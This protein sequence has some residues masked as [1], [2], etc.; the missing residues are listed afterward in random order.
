MTGGTLVGTTSRQAPLSL[1][2]EWKLHFRLGL[3]KVMFLRDK[4][5]AQERKDKPFPPS[6][7]FSEATSRERSV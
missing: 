1:L 2:P 5:W 3:F 7:F 4:D 6:L